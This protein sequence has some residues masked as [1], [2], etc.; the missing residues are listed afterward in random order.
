MPVYLAYSGGIPSVT[1]PL[2]AA[3]APVAMQEPNLVSRTSTMAKNTSKNPY[4]TLK[5]NRTVR[6]EKGL[7][8][9]N[10]KI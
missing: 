4:K 5:K 3:Y 10:N 6:K 7:V 8:G 9:L 2:T 1:V